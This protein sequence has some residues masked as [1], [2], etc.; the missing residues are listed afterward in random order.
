MQFRSCFV[1]I[2]RKHIFPRNCQ[3]LSKQKFRHLFAELH[4]TLFALLTGSI[5]MFNRRPVSNTS[6]FQIQ[7]VHFPSPTLLLLTFHISQQAMKFFDHG[8]KNSCTCPPFSSS[9]H[10]LYIVVT[11]III[12][13]QQYLMAPGLFHFHTCAVRTLVFLFKHDHGFHN[14]FAQISLYILTY[15]S[16]I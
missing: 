7:M 8:K 14:F 15:I 6:S 5:L 3:L 10:I 4:L 1:Q 12:F 13:R 9:F 11:L 16:N 2:H